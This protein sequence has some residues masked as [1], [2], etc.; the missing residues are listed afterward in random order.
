VTKCA[1]EGAFTDFDKALANCFSGR[2]KE[3]QFKSRREGRFSFKL[4]NDRFSLD[5]YSVKISKLG[6]VNMTEMLRFQGKILGAVITREAEWW[7][8]AI[9]V[10]IPDP[11]FA[12]IR[13]QVGIDL[14]IQHL[15]TLSDGTFIENPRAL[16]RLLPRLARLHRIL[17][18]KQK[19]SKNHKK[20]RRKI[21]RIQKRIR[22]IRDDNLHKATTW[23]AKN[24]GDVFI[25]DLNIP[26]M[27]KMRS[28]HD[29]IADAAWGR[30]LK[31]LEYKIEQNKGSLVRIG[32]EPI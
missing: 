18:K 13:G 30:F 7:Y 23:I 2:G 21:A 32:Y 17:K 22:D 20:L 19:G 11:D 3:P 14:G 29:H 27:I 15:A 9:T 25:E 1:T 10:E 5:E 24:Y 8:I 16:A 6:V 4:N 12:P 28:L 31:F 26:A